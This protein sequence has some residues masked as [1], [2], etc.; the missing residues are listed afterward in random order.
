MLE[1]LQILCT[2]IMI[3]VTPI[4]TGKV[5]K[6]WVRPRFKGDAAKF[7]I[8]YRKQLTMFIWL[9]AVFMAAQ[10]ALG[11]MMPGTDSVNL[12]SKVVIGVL[13]G[14]VGLTGYLSRRR[15]DRALPGLTAA[16][17]ETPAS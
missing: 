3:I 6:G 7:R 16:A 1:I 17:P 2:A 9:G 15:L 5:V 14:G 13:W 4:E 11:A 12:I 8:A 10:V